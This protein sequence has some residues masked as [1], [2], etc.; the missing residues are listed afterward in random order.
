M[1]K[2]N[3]ELQRSSEL[4]NALDIT[5]M[6]HHKYKQ[7]TET[8]KKISITDIYNNYNQYSVSLF[9]MGTNRIVTD[10]QVISKTANCPQLI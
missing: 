7:L 5:E 4:T 3:L 1:K 10:Y 6:L 8:T 2:I 9:K